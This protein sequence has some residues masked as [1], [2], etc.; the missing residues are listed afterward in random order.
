MANERIFRFVGAVLEELVQRNPARR[1]KF[2]S[3]PDIP[4]E[5]IYLE[6]TDAEE[7]ARDAEEALPPPP[8]SGFGRAVAT[9]ANQ[10]IPNNAAT[11]IQFATVNQRGIY[12]VAGQPAAF[13]VPAPQA[14]IY[15]VKIGCRFNEATP[16]AGG[17]ANTGDRALQ[18]RVNGAPVATLRQRASAA[19]DTELV[20]TADLELVVGDI[21]RAGVLQNC[22]GTLPLD[23]RMTFRRV[24]A[25]E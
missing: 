9:R 23:V 5:L 10:V 1:Y 11:L 7:A 22:G 18:I 6:F 4:T 16:G 2:R 19:G 17:T 3:H 8:F 14:G 25:E 21:I 20:A 12:W 13:T 24:P 15:D